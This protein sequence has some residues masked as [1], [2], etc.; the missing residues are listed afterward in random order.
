MRPREENEDFIKANKEIK[1]LIAQRDKLNKEL[2][3]L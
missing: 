2:S 3:D 1:E